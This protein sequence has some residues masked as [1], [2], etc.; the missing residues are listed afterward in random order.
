MGFYSLDL[1]SEVI[2]K[3]RW[4][5]N[6]FICLLFILII[7]LVVFLGCGES[8]NK[9]INM[10]IETVTV[11]DKMVK[12]ERYLIYSENTT[13]QIS[14]SLLL[15][16]WNSSD[17]YGQIMVGETYE[18]RVAGYR[19]PFLSWYPNIYEVVRS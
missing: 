5:V 19:I 1:D 16:R 14:D 13:Y 6:V 3:N 8:I 15:W 11:T 18:I 2:M 10:R 4:F 7:L 17:L 12:E 9:A